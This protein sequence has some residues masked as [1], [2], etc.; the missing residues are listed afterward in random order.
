MMIDA[1]EKL[2]NGPRDGALLRFSLG[3]AHL[4][5]GH[6]MEAIQYFQDTLAHDPH[7]SA[8]WKALGKTLTAA[9]KPDA[10]LEAYRQGIQVA[11]DK[12]DKQAAKEM[13]VFA[14][15]I[16]KSAPI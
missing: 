13:R 14:K 4:Q 2:L 9:G 8:A 16:E 10:A 7:Y 11:E 5:A 12:G 1:L 6:L 3:N 15:R